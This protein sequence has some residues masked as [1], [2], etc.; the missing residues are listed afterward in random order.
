MAK[1]FTLK[2]GGRNKIYCMYK[3]P[4]FF[5]FNKS[6]AGS[7]G[8]LT[9]TKYLFKKLEMTSFT[10]SLSLTHTHFAHTKKINDK[11]SW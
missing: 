8:I 10:H 5:F 6:K 11:N 7:D 1:S 4:F 2:E 9:Q 3:A